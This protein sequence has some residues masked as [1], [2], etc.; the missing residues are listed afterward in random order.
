MRIIEN[1]KPTL[2]V[3]LLSTPNNWNAF[4]N[5]KLVFKRVI[6]VYGYALK[7]PVLYCLLNAIGHD[8][9]DICVWRSDGNL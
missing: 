6:S 7:L 5:F 8:A 3:L 1:H 4:V 2:P 9:G